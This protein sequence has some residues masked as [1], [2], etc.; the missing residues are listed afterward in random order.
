MV[1]FV[2]KL[3]EIPFFKYVFFD[4][5]RDRGTQFF[6]GVIPLDLSLTKTLRKV[7]SLHTAMIL[8]RVSETI[9]FQSN[10]S[11]GCKVKDEREIG[12]SLKAFSVPKI[13][14]LFQGTNHIRT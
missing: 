13:I 11:A 10:K 7:L 4:Q 3:L 8:K 12:S 2:L 5:G 9:F 14:H 1:K 6:G